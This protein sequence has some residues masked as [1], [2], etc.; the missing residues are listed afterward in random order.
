[1]RFECL[2]Q[3]LRGL[4]WNRPVEAAAWQDL[5]TRV[6]WRLWHGQ[7]F[8]V[9]EALEDI[10]NDLGP[11][12]RPFWQHADDSPLTRLLHALWAL[13]AFLAAN[14]SSLV[15]YAARY[16]RGERIS[17]AVVES[18]VNRVIGRRM[19]KKQQMRW[20]RRGAHLLIQVRLAVLED[21]LQGAFR[22]WYPRFPLPVGREATPA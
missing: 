9:I 14:A 3:I 19:A 6:K 8:R 10:E 4:H 16:R 2:H 18:M 15:N 20:S 5:A 7:H 13:Q 22:R 21:A 11:T 17:T 1:M 12:E